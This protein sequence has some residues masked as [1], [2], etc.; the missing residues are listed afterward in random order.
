MEA[1]EEMELRLQ[2]CLTPRGFSDEGMNAMDQMI[3]ELAGEVEERESFGGHRWAWVSGAAAAGIAL[4]FGITWVNQ[5]G[6]AD[7]PA[8]LAD[9][10]EPI[11]LVSE[12]VGVVA[13][14]V[15]DQLIS[16]GDGNLM[17]AWH[18]QVVNQE[19]FH[20]P[21]TG[22]EVTVVRPRDEVVLMPVSSF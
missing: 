22:H 20:D 3:D 7:T 16:D 11:S 6:M 17:R 15:D 14:E 2:R 21:Q 19:R 4:A 18:V 10:V 13:A 8:V 5:I 9:F 1:P 12:E